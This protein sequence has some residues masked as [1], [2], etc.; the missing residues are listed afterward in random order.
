MYQGL[1]T[2]FIRAQFSGASESWRVYNRATHQFFH[3]L[4]EGK[5]SFR[6]AVLYE[7]VQAA[8]LTR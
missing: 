7:V 6:P 3:P 5:P 1:N 8:R 2:N 4:E